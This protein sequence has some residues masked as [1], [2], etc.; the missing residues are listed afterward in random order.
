M[1]PKIDRGGRA[2]ALCKRAVAHADAGISIPAGHPIIDD[3]RALF[4]D[5]PEPVKDR[6]RDLYNYVQSVRN[7]LEQI[8][9]A[10]ERILGGL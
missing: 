4:E 8:D 7:D 5:A 9:A 3:M 2:I 6:V 1:I 10:I